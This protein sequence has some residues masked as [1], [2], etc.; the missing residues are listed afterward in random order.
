MKVTID[1]PR[2]GVHSL[3]EKTITV[4]RYTGDGVF[5][6]SLRQ[7][8]GGQYFSGTFNRQSVEELATA[9]DVLLTEDAEEFELSEEDEQ[10]CPSYAAIGRTSGDTMALFITEHGAHAYIRGLEDGHNMK[11]VDIKNDE[12]VP[13]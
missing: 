5:D 9:L 11:I 13:A 1:C 12:R 6:I 2:D 7:N 10:F 8:D 3:W 4:K